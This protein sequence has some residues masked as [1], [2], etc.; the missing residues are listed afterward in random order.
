VA[1]SALRV[2]LLL[3]APCADRD[4]AVTLP[5]FPTAETGFTAAGISLEE[6]LACAAPA[7]TSVE[8]PLRALPTTETTVAS[9]LGCTAAAWVSAGTV[10][11]EA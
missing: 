9:V 2:E 7:S 5:R 6:R 11:D 1:D 8:L 3:P 10:E 4:E